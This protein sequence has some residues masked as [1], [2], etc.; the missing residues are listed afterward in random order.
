MESN[1]V[2][3]LGNGTS[4]RDHM[5]FVRS[6]EGEIWAC[7]WAYL[8]LIDG[9]LHRID[10]LI[11]DKKALIRALEAKRKY[12]FSYECICKGEPQDELSECTPISSLGV[13]R[14]R[15]FDSGSALVE[16]A[17]YEGYEKIYLVGFDLGGKDMY[18]TEH[19]KRNKSA[20]IRKWRQLD[21]QYGLDRVE[22]V[23]V[24]HKWFIQS[25]LPPDYYA[26]FYTR[27]LN[28]LV[29]GFIEDEKY[30]DDVIILENGASKL[31][32]NQ[33]IQ[34][35]DREIWVMDRGFIEYNAL[36][37]IHRVG[38]VQP[39]TA[40]EAVEYKRKKGLNYAVYCRD[41]VKD[42]ESELHL[43]RERR[44]WL[45][46]PLMI[47]Q[48]LYEEY[49]NIYLVG[50]DLGEEDLYGKNT[51]KSRNYATQLLT[52]K[53]EFGAMFDERVHLLNDEDTLSRLFKQGE[54][55]KKIQRRRRQ[56]V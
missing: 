38:T 14:K 7:N 1:A 18:I 51:L 46:G 12:G 32:Y 17:L 31:R 9:S 2:L 30:H 25:Q 27:G 50:F 6:W 33:Y 19:D 48:A 37:A 22:F 44:G 35:W 11:G 23:G 21:S 3:I 36:P 8:E 34:H 26:K 41:F 10:R 13:S 5:E 42:Y 16:L 43:F 54:Y 53:K 29:G 45:A 47:A 56:R 39:R 55:N 20:W 40:I 24:D 15:L 52:V 49:N 28:H 4:R